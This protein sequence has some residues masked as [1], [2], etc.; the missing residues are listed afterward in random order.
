MQ[1]PQQPQ[2]AQ[3]PEPVQPVAPG[4]PGGPY[5]LTTRQVSGPEAVLAAARAQREELSNQLE[6][7][8]EKRRA[9]S[10]ELRRGAEGGN[11]EG[12]DRRISELDQ[13]ISE[14]DKQIAAAD[15]AVAKAAA[16]PGAVVEHPE[17]PPMPDP[18]PPEGVVIMTTVFTLFVLF[19][20]TIAYAR[21]LWRRGAVAVAELPKVLAERLTRLDQAVD[22]I[23][24]EVERISEGQRFLTK[25]MTDNSGR[26]L[27][28]G[29]AQPV[30]VNAREGAPIARSTS[31]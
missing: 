8:E 3:L 22:T 19:P 11:R 12:I 30:E 24:I 13:R 31:R 25:V 17:P 27:A 1:Q 28:V 16:I 23:A 4:T 29:S 14:V 20:L 18:G 15:L 9:L 6:R 21:R 26:A 10:Q 5:I 2:P 7:L